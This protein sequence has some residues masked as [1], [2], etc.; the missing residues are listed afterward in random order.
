MKDPTDFCEILHFVQNDIFLYT[1]P[2]IKLALNKKCGTVLYS[3]AG[4]G[5]TYAWPPEGD[6]DCYTAHYRT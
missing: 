2:F 6:Q 1:P 4:G 3:D 5:G